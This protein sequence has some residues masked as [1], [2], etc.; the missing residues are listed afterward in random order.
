MSVMDKFRAL[1]FAAFFR[2]WTLPASLLIYSS[3]GT[4][5]PEG[6]TQ[7]YIGQGKRADIGPQESGTTW[8]PSMSDVRIVERKILS[9]NRKGFFKKRIRF[10]T[11]TIRNGQKLIEGSAWSS[12]DGFLPIALPKSLKYG[13]LRSIN[14]IDRS[15]MPWIQFEKSIPSCPIYLI[16]YDIS[17]GVMTNQFCYP[18]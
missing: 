4:A 18:M 16:T 11:G 5:A 9:G 12:V 7:A 10:Y 14:I 8:T 17:A 15:Q 3:V 1:D 2:L 13:D 6:Q